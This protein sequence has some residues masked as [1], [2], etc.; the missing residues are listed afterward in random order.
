MRDVTPAAGARARC[1]GD[2]GGDRPGEREAFA[3]S[4]LA[5]PHGP[6]GRT[7]RAGRQ[8]PVAATRAAASR[9]SADFSIF[10]VPVTGTA[11]GSIRKT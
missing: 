8:P 4:N 6:Q 9:R 3:Q 10:P 1:H 11:D 5:P 2:P 7:V